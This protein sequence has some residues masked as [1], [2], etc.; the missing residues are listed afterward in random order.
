MAKSRY[1]N[2]S[3]HIHNNYIRTQTQ[4]WVVN[5]D[6]N[7]GFGFFFLGSQL[8]QILV[9]KSGLPL[10]SSQICVGDQLGIMMVVHSDW[11]F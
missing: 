3:R 8:G 2:L 7:V 11:H 5:L 10:L 6:D 1:V 9:V 4:P